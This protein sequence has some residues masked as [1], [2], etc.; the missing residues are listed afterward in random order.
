VRTYSALNFTRNTN[1]LVALSRVAKV[2]STMNHDQYLAGIW[3][4]KLPQALM[5]YVNTPDSTLRPDS[6]VAPSW[7]W[8]SAV[9]EVNFLAISEDNSHQWNEVVEIVDAET[10]PL[11]PDLFGEISQGLIR[12]RG[13]LMRV[14]VGAGG[15]TLHLE[16]E[17]QHNEVTLTAG[18][19]VGRLVEKQK[20][21]CLPIYQHAGLCLEL[22]G[23]ND[24]HYRRVGFWATGHPRGPSA[25]A[26]LCKSFNPGSVDT[27][28]G[29][30][31]EVGEDPGGDNEMLRWVVSLV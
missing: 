18:A 13:G 23:R 28:N 31:R 15:K 21:Y 19:D 4:R 30:V 10:F 9:G 24:G 14:T 27:P 6:I 3:R 20:L 2:V 11:S 17:D 5:W 26:A 16:D 1:R 25:V 12:L 8:A 29:Q 22:D 7:S